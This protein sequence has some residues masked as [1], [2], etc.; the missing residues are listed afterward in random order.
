MQTELFTF[1]YTELYEYL[2]IYA[3]MKKLSLYLRKPRR[4]IYE[5]RDGRAEKEEE[6]DIIVT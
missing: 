5:S 3:F 1:T 2:S 4:D 6:N